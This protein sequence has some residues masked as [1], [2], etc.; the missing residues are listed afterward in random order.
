[1]SEKKP[2]S[3]VA[4]AGNLVT[5][6][7]VFPLAF[8]AGVLVDRRLGAHDRGLFTFVLLL[9]GFVL[10]L[11]TFGFGGAV[12]YFVSSGKYRA[13][14]I[15]FTSLVVGA[16]QGLLSSLLFWV[17]WRLGLLG[18]TGAETT[19][20]ELLPMLLLAPLQGAQLMGTRVLFGESRFGISNVLNVARAAASPLLLVA[21]VV[22]A[23][24]EL[25]GAVLST[26]VLEVG[27]TLGTVLTLHPL[28]MVYR[29]DTQFFVESMR[30]GIKM[31]IGDVATRANLRLDQMLLGVFAPSAALGNYS[32][33]VRMS[34]F[35]WMGADSVAP[36]LFNRLAAAPDDEARVSLIGRVHRL[37]FAAMVA[38]ALGCGVVGYFAIPF[39][40]GKPYAAAGVLFELLLPGTVLLYTA[41]VL[42]KHF[43]A[44][45]KPEVL[46]RLGVLSGLVGALS[47]FALI[48]VGATYGA[49]IGSSLSYAFMS[50]YALYLYRRDIAPRSA[51]L[52]GIRR[53]DLTWLKGQLSRRARR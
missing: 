28:R 20:R 3:S 53:D 8:L 9:G 30:Y 32:V 48:P 42:T 34:E 1:M 52:F 10:P 12:I 46:G 26:T 21:F 5:K 22:V 36:V 14:A 7:V 47:Y 38:L 18:Q 43:A 15:S 50:G 4:A 24:M 29:F 13:E 40:F 19:W 17:L 11:L 44:V 23:K 25:W 33:A 39:A 2:R 35:L 37:G 51:D 6:V 45:A 41:K 31:W 16:A 27:M 49:A